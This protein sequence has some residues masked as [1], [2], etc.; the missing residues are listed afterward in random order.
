[1]QAAI[2][3]TPQEIAGADRAAIEAFLEHI[4]SRDGVADLT[5]TAYRSDL[6]L[7]AAWLRARG[8]SLIG[9]TYENL[10]RYLGERGETK[11]IKA[12]SNARLLTV[13]RRFYADYARAR[14][15]R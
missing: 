5:L 11:K 3:E 10:A 15:F 1:M 12:R 2:A 9:A 6:E 14:G 4:W 8:A 13:L 7:C